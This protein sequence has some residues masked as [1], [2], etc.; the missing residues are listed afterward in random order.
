[1]KPKEYWIRKTKQGARFA[2]DVPI[3]GDNLTHVVEYSDF[4]KVVAVLKKLK[5]TYDIDLVKDTLKELGF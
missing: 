5:T 2:Y 4:D 3:E 1:M